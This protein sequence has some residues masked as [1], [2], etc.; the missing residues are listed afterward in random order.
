MRGK[1]FKRS[2]KSHSDLLTLSSIRSRAEMNVRCEK[3]SAMVADPRMAYAVI[4]DVFGIFGNKQ[5]F[6]ASPATHGAFQ[7]LRS[8]CGKGPSYFHGT[9]P[10][11]LPTKD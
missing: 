1:A 7:V 9:S 6:G 4:V 11:P 5:R 2:Y 8:A 3:I 10:M